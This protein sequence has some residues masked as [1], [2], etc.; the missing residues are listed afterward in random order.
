[1]LAAGLIL[2]GLLPLARAQAWNG[3]VVPTT[4]PTTAVPMVTMTQRAN[5]CTVHV[6]GP[7]QTLW[8]I[9]LAY[10]VK[11]DDIRG[12]NGMGTDSTTIYPGEN[13]VIRCLPQP[14]SAAASATEPLPADKRISTPTHAAST[15]TRTAAPASPPTATPS[16]ALPK[17]DPSGPP[18]A[19]VAGLLI[20][21]GGTLLVLLAFGFIRKR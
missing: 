8:A 4:A 14:A 20:L 3:A 5:G 10:G 11:I 13:L 16:A 2:A 17:A 12:L 21:G 1:M 9:A 7:G 19:I 6:V 18:R 15:L